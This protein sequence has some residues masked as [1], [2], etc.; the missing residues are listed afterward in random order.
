MNPK[1]K[2]KIAE[3]PTVLAILARF[4]GNRNAARN[5]CVDLSIEQTFK[6]KHLSSE[7]LL[8]AEQLSA[9]AANTVNP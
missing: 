4:N 7:Y 9:K 8:L 2:A 3:Q 5:Y 1:L 6:N